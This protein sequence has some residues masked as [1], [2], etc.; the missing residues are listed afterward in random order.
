MAESYYNDPAY[1]KPTL[2]ERFGGALSRLGR[3]LD[4]WWSIASILWQAP[5]AA[6]SSILSAVGGWFGMGAQA[7]TTLVEALGKWF[8]WGGGLTGV[9]AGAVAAGSALKAGS[10][11]LEGNWRKAITFGAR[12]TTEAAV[13]MVSGLTMGLAEVVSLVATGRFLSTVAGDYVE[14]NMREWVG[15]GRPRTQGEG[16]APAMQ[17]EQG[18]APVLQPQVGTP[19]MATAM[20][21]QAPV[22]YMMAP[23]PMMQPGMV[24]QVAVPAA[25]VAPVPQAMVMAAPP[26]VPVTPVA[27]TPT[28]PAPGAPVGQWTAMVSA[29]GHAP[30]VQ[31]QQVRTLAV[32]PRAAQ[33]FAQ[34]EAA[35]QAAAMAAPGPVVS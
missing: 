2:L 4:G 12:G 21:P 1:S 24:P 16:L 33:G 30:Q 19:M 29:Q 14:K 10:A 25:A 9:F 15:T 32:E 11:V 7:P 13:T 5:I 6:G 23:Q 26:V 3:V 34:A 22:Y 28:A 17:P 31:G 18:M 27:V 8:D 35:R 20:A